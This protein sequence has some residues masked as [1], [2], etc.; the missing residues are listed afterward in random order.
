MKACW[1]LALYFAPASGGIDW[2]TGLTEGVFGC[3]FILLF[4]KTVF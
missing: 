3:V 2:K 1:G 4:Y